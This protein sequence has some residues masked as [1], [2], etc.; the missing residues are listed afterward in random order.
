MVKPLPSIIVYVEVYMPPRDNKACIAPITY[1]IVM[2]TILSVR[3][4]KCVG[5]THIAVIF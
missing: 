1:L 4:H 5:M 2:L 3:A